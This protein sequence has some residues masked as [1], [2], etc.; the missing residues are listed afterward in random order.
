MHSQVLHAGP[1]ALDLNNPGRYLHWSFIEISVANLIVIVVMMII[2]GLALLI[3]FPHSGSALPAEAET[4]DPTV[5]AAAA[6]PGDADMWTAKA[7]TKVA[8]LLPPKKL[9]QGAPDTVQ[10][11]SCVCW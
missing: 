2:F 7:R 4:E 11:T 3:R 1:L 10:D 9:L 8:G 6:L 5:T